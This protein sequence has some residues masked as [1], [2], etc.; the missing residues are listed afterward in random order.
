MFVACAGLASAA[1]AQDSTPKPAGRPVK[2]APQ[3]KPPPAPP[4]TDPAQP[5]PADA[6]KKDRP[7]PELGP[8]ITQTNPRDLLLTVHIALNSD[9]PTDRT[10]YRDPF[11]GQTV[12]M[13][14]VKPFEFQTLAMVF[15]LLPSTAS[16]D[17]YPREFKGKLTVN[18]VLAS[19]EA[20]I[21][22]GYPGGVKLAR[23]DSNDKSQATTCRQ[24]ELLLEVPTRCYRVKFDEAAALKVPWPQGPWPKDAAS[25]LAP[26]LYVETGVDSEGHVRPYEDK[27]VT[28]TLQKWLS[29][30]GISDPKRVN[31]VA[32]AKILTGKVWGAIQL[33]REGLSL[34]RT[35]EL[36]GVVLQPAEWTLQSGRGAPHDAVVLLAAVLRKTGLPTRVMAGWDVGKGDGKFLKK[37]DKQ[38][39]LRTW[40]EFCLYDEEA[41][42]INWVPIDIVKLRQSTSRPPAVTQNWRYFGANDELDSVVPFAMHFHPPTDVVSYGW[43]GF[44][45]WFVTPK[46]PESAEQSI[47][48]VGTTLSVRGGQPPR[49]PKKKEDETRPP[50]KRGGY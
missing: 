37:G 40:V 9:S 48:F 15:P 20:K 7:A 32:L 8:Y 24:V 1:I 36:S 45:G 50:S 16:S 46:P 22:T 38:N 42:T 35:G 17:P 41:N 5:N 31:P 30:E 44:W 26:Q 47:R 14:T 49:D 23:F 2:Q 6:P 33:D 18:D 13:P 25:I 29:D 4:A 34:K 28:Q 19:E 12:D 21:M 11:T 3:P 10:Q 43:P 27:L 39:K